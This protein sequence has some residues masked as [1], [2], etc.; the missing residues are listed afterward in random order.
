MSTSTSISAPTNSTRGRSQQLGLSDGPDALVDGQGHLG[1]AS[2]RQHHPPGTDVVL[3][4]LVVGGGGGGVYCW[5]CRCCMCGR[6]VLHIPGHPDLGGHL[7]V[8]SILVEQQQLLLGACLVLVLVLVE[9]I[10]L[11]VIV[12]P[13]LHAHHALLDV[14]FHGRPVLLAQDAF[15]SSAAL[16]VHGRGTI[17]SAAKGSLEPLS[18]IAAAADTTQG[19]SRITFVTLLVL[20]LV[21]IF[22]SLGNAAL[23]GGAD[24]LTHEGILQFAPLL[25]LQYAIERAGLLLLLL[26]RIIIQSS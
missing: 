24:A 26:L 14:P 21:G 22:L 2:A 5:T 9:H 25:G 23:L 13:T 19:S 12:A 1:N 18:Q 15:S 11:I 6:L 3:L 20:D 16:S 4:G 7:S 10:A 17:A 8:K